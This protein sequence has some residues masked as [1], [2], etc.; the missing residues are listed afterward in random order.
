MNDLKAA[1]EA[2]LAHLSA[3]PWEFRDL[4]KMGVLPSEREAD[5]WQQMVDARTAHLEED[6][7]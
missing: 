6:S 7:R 1:V 3:D 4:D 2:Y 5:L